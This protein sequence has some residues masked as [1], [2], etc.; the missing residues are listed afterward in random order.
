M[1]Q[2]GEWEGFFLANAQQMLA[3]AGGASEAFVEKR[4]GA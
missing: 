2:A 3:Q 4:G 1:L